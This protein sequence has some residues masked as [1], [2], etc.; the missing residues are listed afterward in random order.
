MLILT[1]IFNFP[2]GRIKTKGC[3]RVMGTA[4]RET[5][6]RCISICRFVSVHFYLI[7]RAE[8]S[9]F[10][11][12]DSKRCRISL[13]AKMPRL[14]AI[15]SYSQREGIARGW[16]VPGR[17]NSSI[18]FPAALLEV[19]FRSLGALFV[20]RPKTASSTS[21]SAAL[22]CPPASLTL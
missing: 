13:P 21:L 6:C 15:C 16:H 3:G 17:G 1:K 2:L 9:Y 22:R 7:K 5:A 19:I 8:I 20:Q 18:A 10:C 14:P 4:P 12:S 11:P